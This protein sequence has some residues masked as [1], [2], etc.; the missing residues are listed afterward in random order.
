MSE[1]EKKRRQRGTRVGAVSVLAPTGGSPY[2]RLTW[3][4]P[5][6]R[7]GRTSGGRAEAGARAKAAEINAMLDRAAGASGAMTLGDIKKLYLSS[8]EGRN[9]KTGGDWT[10]THGQGQR[11]RSTGRCTAS[12]T[13]RAGTST[14]PSSTG[15]APRRARVAP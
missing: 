11:G 2:Y 10:E 9:H 6:G 3:T 7:P 4:E 8:C 14:G 13:C 15:C 1:Q 12:S 5:D